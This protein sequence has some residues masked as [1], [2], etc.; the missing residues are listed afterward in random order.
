MNQEIEVEVSESLL[1]AHS[2]VEEDADTST[3]GC[4]RP[5]YHSWSCL[6]SFNFAG[7]RYLCK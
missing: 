5:L 3:V 4:C 1:P 7:P 6:H 2:V